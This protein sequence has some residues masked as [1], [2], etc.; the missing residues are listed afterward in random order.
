MK[1]LQQALFIARIETRFFLR[2]PKLLLATFAVALMPAIYVLIYLSSVWDPDARTEALPVALVNQDKGLEYRNQVFNV[3]G[4][5]IAT[6]K[7]AKKFGYTDYTQPE[8]AREDVRRGKLAFAL[9]IPA[10]FSANAIPGMLSG[11]AKPIVYVSEGNNYDSGIIARQFAETLRRQL[12]ESLNE[13][14]WEMVL[15]NASGAQH[16][17]NNLHAAVQKL[18]LGAKQLSKGAQ[19]TASGSR[20]LANNTPRLSAGVEQL[21][22]GFK[23]LGTGLKTLESKLPTNAELNRLRNGARSLASGQDSFGKG[24]NELHAGSQQLLAGINQF[25]TETDNSLF[26]P[27]E[28]SEGAQKLSG[29]AAQLDSG[30][31]TARHEHVK[32]VDGARQL[33]TGVRSLTSGL[34]TMGENIRQ[35]VA[36]LPADSRLDELDKG[37]SDFTGHTS[38]LAQATR[39]VA[40]G[41]QMLALGL[42]ELVRALPASLPKPDGS[43]QGLA[44]S[45][46]PQV[47]I[48]APVANSGSGF[49]PNVL[50]AALWLGA[51]IAAFLLHVRV[52]PHKT[53]CYSRLAQ[54]AGKIAFPAGIVLLQ[55]LIIGLVMLVLLKIRI[56]NLLP[57]ALVL[58]SSALTFLLIVFALTRA[59]GDAGKA[60]AMVLLALQLSSSGG[61]L[62]VE[63]SGS[64]FALIS[65]WLPLTWVVQ[66]LKASMFGAYNHDW[67]GALTHL[68]PWTLVA[69]LMACTIG[70]WR[71]INPEDHRPAVDL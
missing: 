2:H 40:T 14:R 52:L 49:A 51:G 31:D 60:L 46:A 25:K 39:D 63:L 66:A 42:D 36:R 20:Q 71:F 19:D 54:V 58:I 48:A 3:G 59:F 65:P 1:L 33:N 34:R 4:D 30:L 57:F 68:A 18:S 23:Q 35:A 37:T 64:L 22:D 47:E 8:Q 6:L 67:L 27:A 69:L 61:I 7:R 62:P 53:Q 5:V 15:S 13:Q 70:R 12:N 45:V 11:A 16:D 29:G 9:I 17:I 43:A 24:L 55:T 28:V 50:A 44:H 41:A 10:D 26:I 21:T 56:V 32:L 38:K